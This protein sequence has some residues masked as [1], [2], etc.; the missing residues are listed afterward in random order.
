MN[1]VQKFEQQNMMAFIELQTLEKQSK[2]IEDRKAEVREILTA[3][4]EEHGIKSIDNEYVKIVYVAP[5]EST[6]LDTKK[7]RAEEPDTYNGLMKAYSKVTK[8]KGSVRITVK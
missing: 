2:T 3:G 5:S 8:R 6:S 7:L 1:E 4:M